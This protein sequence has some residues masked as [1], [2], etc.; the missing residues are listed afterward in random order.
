VTPSAIIS[1]AGALAALARHPSPVA[2]HDDTAPS[3]FKPY[4]LKW[5][6][7]RYVTGR[8]WIRQPPALLNADPQCDR[9]L[10]DG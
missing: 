10:R 7:W 8:P 2:E 5:Q 6:V 1:A 3:H 9:A 4:N